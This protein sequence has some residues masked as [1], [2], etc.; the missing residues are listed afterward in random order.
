MPTV[1]VF[2]WSVIYKPELIHALL[3]IRTLRTQRSVAFKL[4]HSKIGK[5]HFWVTSAL[6]II[7]LNSASIIDIQHRNEL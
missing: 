1:C 2:I 3:A 5:C 7:S 4:R 6:S